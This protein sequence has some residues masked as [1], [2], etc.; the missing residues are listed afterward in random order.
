[1]RPLRND[2][3]TLAKERPTPSAA[4]CSAAKLARFLFARTDPLLLNRPETPDTDRAVQALNDAV[5]ALLGQARAHRAW[6]NEPALAGT[7]ETLTTIAPQWQH[8]PDFLTD[9]EWE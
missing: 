7:W 5:R 1:M 3:R 6:G 4:A 8:H 2:I 9:W